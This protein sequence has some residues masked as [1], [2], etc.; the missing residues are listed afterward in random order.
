MLYVK[1]TGGL[2]AYTITENGILKGIWA[3]GKGTETLIP[4]R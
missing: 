4:H 2:V 1:W 3:D